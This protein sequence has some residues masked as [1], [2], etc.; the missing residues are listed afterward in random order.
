LETG[1]AQFMTNAANSRFF[2]SL[3]KS[4]ARAEAVNFH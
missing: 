4:S 2:A 1:H 3:A